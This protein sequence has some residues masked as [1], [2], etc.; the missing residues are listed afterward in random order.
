MTLDWI[1]AKLT[2]KHYLCF[3]CAKYL[4]NDCRNR[5]DNSNVYSEGGGWCV[6]IYGKKY[7]IAISPYDLMCKNFRFKNHLIFK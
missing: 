4:S 6:P 5:T 7:F 3:N 1:K 2:G